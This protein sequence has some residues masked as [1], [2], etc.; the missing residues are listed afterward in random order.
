MKTLLSFLSIETLKH[1]Q[2]RR[3]QAPSAL[4]CRKQFK[5][6]EIYNDLKP[7]LI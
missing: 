3:T 5:Q 4:Y 2:D 6:Q 1:G 7:K